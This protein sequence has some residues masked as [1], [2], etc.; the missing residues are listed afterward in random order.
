MTAQPRRADHGAGDPPPAEAQP[1]SQ[2]PEARPSEVLPPSATNTSGFHAA[3]PQ[4]QHVELNPTGK[5]LAFLSLTALGIVYGDI[6]T[7]PLYALQQCF[8]SKEFSI[9]PTP[10]NV[11]GVLSL[12]VWLL[13][14][15]VAVKYILFIMRADNRGEGGI[16][17]LM[18][19][20]LQTERRTTDSRRRWILIMLGLFGAAL[21]YGDGIITPSITVLSAVDG[22]SVVTPAFSHIIVPLALIILFVLFSCQR[23]GTG[24]IGAMFGPIMALWFV[25]IAALGMTQ[26]V[27]HPRILGALN[28]WH[29]VTF[30]MTNGRFAFL[31]LGA[32][33]L[34]VTGAEALYA[35]MGHFGKRPIRIAWFSLVLPALLLNYLGQG[36]LL[37][38]NPA[39]VTNPFYMLA[40]RVMLI[41]LVVLA[42]VAAVIASQALI[43]GAFSLTQQAI[44]LGY[45]P[46]TTVVHTSAREVGQIF[47]PEINRLLMLG[48]LLL[49]LAFKSANALG[50][51]Y[52]IAVTGTMAITSI[53]F[54]VVARAQWNWSLWHAL[55]IAVAFF[56]IDVT[57][58]A[59]NVIK[60]ESGG[61]VP[62]AVAAS[63]FTLMT[64]WKRGRGLLNSALNSGSLPLDL[65][66]GDVAR[67]KPVRVP[68]TAVFMTS[69]NDG[70]PVVLLHHLKHNKVLHEQ[71]ILMSVITREVPEVRSSERVSVEKLEH[72]FYRVTARYGFMES[73]NVP[74]ILQWARESGIKAR[75]NDT[76]FYLGRERIIISDGER[77]PGTRRAPD[78]AVLPRMARWRKKL[79]VV[80]TRN[81][82]SATEFFG[83][84]PNRVVELGAQVEF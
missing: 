31:S 37:I 16:L 84:P 72:G 25:T 15:V 19:L 23:F 61:W 9:A 14:L 48:C 66:L 17:A 33:V 41:P 56:M 70:V 26:I 5:R 28:P 45:S 77:K 42:A 58:F 1:T 20:I 44:Q 67:R 59:A 55:P 32:V 50:A 29:G 76:T 68:G 2:G 63:V 10:E 12:I 3:V 53:L 57:L 11:F 75:P 83:I 22:V 18:A 64:T 8:T 13:V 38:E 52:G 46:R 74:E 47:I 78:D 62:I 24:R 69:S 43:S 35:D 6:G 7:S 60:I 34:A 21:L 30:F 49:V 71:V 80:M 4:R 27:R 82:R 81:A 51:A 73:P 54:F 79:F 40:P 65:F 39:A 36:A